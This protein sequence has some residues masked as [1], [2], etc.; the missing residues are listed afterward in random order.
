MVS[1]VSR[2]RAE[3]EAP[4]MGGFTFVLEQRKTYTVGRDKDCH[5]RFESRY[6]KPVQGTLTVGDWDPNNV[7]RESTL[8]LRVQEPGRGRV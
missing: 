7:S 4:L 6:V 5:I 2:L 3:L 1:K 8:Q